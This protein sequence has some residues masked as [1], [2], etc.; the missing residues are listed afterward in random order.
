MG[1]SSGSRTGSGR[2]IR[3]TGGIPSPCRATSCPPRWRCRGRAPPV[4][5]RSARRFSRGPRTC[6]LNAATRRPGHSGHWSAAARRRAARARGARRPRRPRSCRDRPARSPGP[7]RA[8]GSPRRR[9]RGGRAA[10]RARDVARRSRSPRTT[11]PRPTGR[12]CASRCGAACAARPN[13]PRARRRSMRCR[14]ARARGAPSASSPARRETGRP[15]RRIWPRCCG[16]GAACARSP[17]AGPRRRPA[18][19]YH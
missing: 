10:I 6:T 12:R 16:S 17:P 5:V 3:R 13:Q 15:C 14:Q 1:C 18:R 11:S 7:I 2:G 4:P 19:V 8:R 9:R